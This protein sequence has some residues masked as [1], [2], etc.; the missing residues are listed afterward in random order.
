MLRK[1][2]GQSLV[3]VA[4]VLPVVL[5]LFI[6]MVEVGW[7]MHSYVTVA[8]AAREATR[9]GARGNFDEE[10]IAEVALVALGALDV[11]LEGPDVNTTVIVTFVDIDPTGTYTV[12]TPYITGTLPVTSSILTGD[13][14]IAQVAAD[15]AAF[16]QDPFHCPVE[17]PP[18]CEVDSVND[19]VVVEAFYEHVQMLGLPIVSNILSNPIPIYSRG[20][21]RVGVSRYD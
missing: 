3:E 14:D 1:E 17:S 12:T 5:L 21:M 16:N 11:Q 15:N 19:L 18:P 6:G 8:T 9:F 7:A 13:L 2:K 10:D 20:L 4:V